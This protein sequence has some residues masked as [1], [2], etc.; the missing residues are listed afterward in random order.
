MNYYNE[1]DPYA[2]QWIRNL[3]DAGQIAPGVV[4]MRSIEDV[5]PNDLKGF[6]QHHFFAG[7]AGWAYAL[8]LAGWP[9]E[10]PVWTGSCPCQP[11]SAAGKGNGFEDERHLWPAWQYLIGQCQPAVIF[12]EQVAS[13]AADPWIDL[14]QSDMEGMGNA[15]GCIAF[16]SAGVGAPHMRDR[17]LW[18]A[19]ATGFG[20][21]WRGT[22]QKG[23]E[24][25][26]IERSHGFCNAGS[27]AD[28]DH[29]GFRQQRNSLGA[30]ARKSES[31]AQERQRFWSASTDGGAID[32]V[33][34]SS[35]E[36][37]D[38]Q[39]VRLRKQ[40]SASDLSEITGRGGPMWP[41]ELGTDPSYVGPFQISAPTGPTNGPWRDAD[42]LFCRDGKWRPVEPGTFP[43]AHGVSNRVGR[44][45]AYGNAINP[46]Q[47]AEFIKSAMEILT[48]SSNCV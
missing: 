33:A 19:R 29:D 12:G 41:G 27:L 30:T 13:K 8:D 22:S 24:P 18:M 11:F 46:W 20:R 6:T 23:R 16:P 5:T 4:D 34:N 40:R 39:H 21:E 32:G 26:Q 2:A 1:I 35:H 17:V 47:V 10:R 31:G 36:R 42:W 44:L 48:A 38:Q 14:V 43:L 25:G 7:L 28:A 3:I 15:F 9:R 45:R 37:R